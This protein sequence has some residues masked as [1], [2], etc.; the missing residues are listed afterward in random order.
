[1]DRGPDALLA[2]VAELG[3][4]SGEF[5]LLITAGEGVR[6]RHAYEIAC[7]LGLPTGMLATLGSSV[8]EQNAE[9]IAALLMDRGAVTS[10]SGWSRSFSTVACLSS[11]L[12]CRHSSGGSRRPA[13]A[14]SPSTAPTPAPFSPPRRLAAG[15]SSTSK[16]GTGCKTATQRASRAAQL[17]PQITASAL[18]ERDLPDLPGSCCDRHAHSRATG[19]AGPADQRPHRA[20]GHASGPRRGGR[21]PHHRRLTPAAR[22]RRPPVTRPSPVVSR[23]R[24]RASWPHAAG[25]RQ[26]VRR[27]DR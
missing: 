25:A 8:S 21:D 1:M 20:D 10:P 4:L 9:I 2:V 24:S 26:P 3:E 16:T 5:P 12:G 22:A 17:M 7:D 11:S 23:R 6:A 13:P 15:P 27:S 14:T 19:A 18:R